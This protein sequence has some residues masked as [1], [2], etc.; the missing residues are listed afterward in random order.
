[1]F[2]GG[3]VAVGCIQVLPK[4]IFIYVNK[5]MSMQKLKKIIIGLCALIVTP[6]I[7]IMLVLYQPSLKMNTVTFE[8]SKGDVV[9]NTEIADS[10][11]KHQVGLMNRTE[12]G[13][14]AGMLFIFSGE[15]PRTF[16]MKNTLIPLDMIFVDS[17]LR[18]VNITKNAKPCNTIACELYPS[19]VPAMYV[20]EVNGG[21]ADKKGIKIGDK[22]RITT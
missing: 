5:K 15:S 10:I 13:Q 7:L 16:W 19:G 4:S 20:V 14:D 21:F 18:V 3:L 11:I 22:I 8:T 17:K 6:V 2:I 1:M 12:L 9:V